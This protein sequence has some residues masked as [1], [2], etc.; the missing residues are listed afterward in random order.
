MLCWIV[1]LDNDLGCPEIPKVTQEFKD[2][3]HNRAMKFYRDYV[4]LCYTEKQILNTE[5]I[6]AHLAT[7]W[8]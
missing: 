5:S 3:R 8:S 2:K 1:L 7:R 4:T 6:V